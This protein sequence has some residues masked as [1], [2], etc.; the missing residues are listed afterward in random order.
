MS[1]PSNKTML[2]RALNDYALPAQ[3]V[4][5]ILA[6]VCGEEFVPF[7]LK[8]DE[9]KRICAAIPN[10]GSRC[11]VVRGPKG[12]RAFDPEAHGRLCKAAREFQTKRHAELRAVGATK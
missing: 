4:K 2:T 7:K 6:R 8:R 11:L 3:T 12:V 9:I 1:R 5:K 10:I